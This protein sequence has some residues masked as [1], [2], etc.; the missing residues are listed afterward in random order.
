MQN[1]NIIQ[2][3][4]SWSATF[5]IAAINTCGLFSPLRFK[6]S[7]EGDRLGCR[8]TATELA[9]GEL[10][11]G[12]EVTIA[13]AKSQGWYGRSGSK[14]PDMP[15]QMLQYRAASS[16]GRIYAAHILAGIA[17]AD[18]A[19][20]IAPAFT[21]ERTINPT[22]ERGEPSE[23]AEINKAAKRGRRSARADASSPPT[24]GRVIE[25]EKYGDTIVIHEEDEG[26]QNIVAGAPA[27]GAPAPAGG[28]PAPAGGAPAPAGDSLDS[29][30]GSAVTEKDLF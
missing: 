14:W 18:E 11:I 6:M 4:P 19:E 24:A 29:A 5:I 8:A 17:V 7:G 21:P 23:I 20:D 25:P 3:R 9:T 15:E 26:T 27:G 22:P 12:A 13:M 30:P 16:F 28:A 2:G 1:L 10:L